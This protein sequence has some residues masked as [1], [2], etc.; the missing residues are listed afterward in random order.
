MAQEGRNLNPVIKKIEQSNYES[1]I[2]IEQRL[3]QELDPMQDDEI[4]ELE[5]K[6]KSTLR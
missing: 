5:G 1:K 3:K 2:F 6:S 4:D